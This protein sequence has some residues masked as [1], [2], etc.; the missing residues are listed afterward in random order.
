VTKLELLNA[1][2][3]VSDMQNLIESCPKLKILRFCSLK[4][5]ISRYVSAREMIAI[6]APLSNSLEE[7]YLDFG[8]KAQ[9]DDAIQFMSHSSAL[10]NP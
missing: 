9:G 2:M 3:R 1:E 8:P 5:Q 10:Q 6:L 7:L 4:E